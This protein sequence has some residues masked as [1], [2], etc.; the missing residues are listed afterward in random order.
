MAPQSQQTALSMLIFHHSSFVLPR[1]RL[2][3]RAAC[4]RACSLT[5]L[6]ALEGQPVEDE[7]TGPKRHRGAITLDTST[8]IHPMG[9]FG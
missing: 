6:F 7:P 8:L 3:R 5:R 2:Q 9:R 4:L 1:P